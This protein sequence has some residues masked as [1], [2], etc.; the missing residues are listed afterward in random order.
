MGCK[1]SLYKIGAASLPKTQSDFQAIADNALLGSPQRS[2][3]WVMV[4]VD[5]SGKSSVFGFDDDAAKDAFSAVTAQTPGSAFVALYEN[6]ELF[7]FSYRPPRIFESRK[8]RIGT[9]WILGGVALGM[10]GLAAGFRQ[11]KG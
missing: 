4:R 1:V 5:D 11:R 3:P 2:R 6:G 9:G 7:D 8:E 10:L